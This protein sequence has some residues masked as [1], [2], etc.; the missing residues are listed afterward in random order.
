VVG[1]R[2]ELERRAAAAGAAWQPHQTLG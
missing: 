1:W 2:G